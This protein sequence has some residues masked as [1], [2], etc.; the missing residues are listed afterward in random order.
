VATKRR[1]A[2]TRAADLS[3]EGMSNEDT[4]EWAIRAL[5]ELGRRAGDVAELLDESPPRDALY[6]AHSFV[7]RVGELVPW[8]A[9]YNIPGLQDAADDAT[10][11]RGRIRELL[12]GTTSDA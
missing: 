5:D 12:S 10:W 11:A 3:F 8:L 7:T 2:L 4:F 6:E 1:A 9:G